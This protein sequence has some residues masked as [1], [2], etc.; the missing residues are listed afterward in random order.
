MYVHIA[1]FCCVFGPRQVE[2]LGVSNLVGTPLLRGYMHGYFMDMKLYTRCM[3]RYFV[4][5]A[6]KHVSIHE[7]RWVCAGVEGVRGW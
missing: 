7:D 1:C 2:E 4:L 6:G 5:V 3:G